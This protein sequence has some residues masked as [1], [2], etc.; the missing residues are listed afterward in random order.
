[1]ELAFHYFLADLLTDSLTEIPIVGFDGTR[2]NFLSSSSFALIRIL[3][4]CL[5]T[6]S[7]LSSIWQL[8]LEFVLLSPEEENRRYS[9]PLLYISPG[10]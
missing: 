5:L 3:V 7:F 8:A 6:S 10:P 1:M 4:F 2:S 9:E